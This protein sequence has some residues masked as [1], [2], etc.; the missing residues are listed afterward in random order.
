MINKV[1]LVTGASQGLGLV[2]TKKLLDNGHQ[3]IATSRN[4]DKIISEI[5][6]NP[7]LLAVE[8][9]MTDSKSI[10]NAIDKGIEKFSTIDILLNNAG[11]GQLW[12]FEETSE[13]EVMKNINANLIGTMNVVRNVLPYMRK[14]KYGHI[15]VTSSAWGFKTVPYNSIYA[16]VKF[17]LDGFA[18]GISHELKPLGISVSSVKPG[19]FRTNFLKEESLVTGNNVIADYAQARDE[20]VN[21]VKSW[22][23]YQDGNPEKYA[24]LLIELSSQ[25]EIPANIFAGRDAYGLAKEKLDILQKD[26]KDLESKATN[27]H[28]E[29]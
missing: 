17:G 9:D 13:E 27:L 16:A 15:F 22:N 1:W 28:F 23:G 11:Y 10:K 19:G 3:V 18:E 21:T 29:G 7:N 14:Q 24:E 25:N 20:W 26:I 4:K 6:E 12:T 8:M 2:V 5:G